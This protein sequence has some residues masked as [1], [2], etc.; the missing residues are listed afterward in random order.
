M[1][2][3]SNAPTPA[4]PNA[5]VAAAARLNLADKVRTRLTTYRP[6]EEWQEEAWAYYD[7]MPELKFG[8]RYLGNAM[9]KLRFFVGVRGDDPSEDPIPVTSEDAAQWVSPDLARLATET[10]DRLRGPLGDL[11]EITRELNSNLE[12]VGEC[13]L[14]G[15]MPRQVMVADPSR[16]GEMAPKLDGGQ[17]VETD[18]DWDIKSVSELKY[19]DIGSLRQHFPAYLFEGLPDETTK[20]WVVYDYPGAKKPSNVILPPTEDRP[21]DALIRIWTK[22]PRFSQVAD[23]P[24]RAL[25]TDCQILQT[26]TQQ[27][28]AEANSRMSAGVFL[29]PSELS[30]GP[31][32]QTDDGSEGGDADGDPLNEEIGNALGDPIA[33]PSSPYSVAPVLIRGPAE[34][35]KE[36]RHLTLDRTSETWL[37]DRIDK[38]IR[39]LANGVN[40][41]PEVL[42]GHDS[43]TF[44]NAKQI[45]QD[46]FDDYLEPRAVLCSNAYTEAFL[47]PELLAAD[48]MEQRVDEIDRLVVW[49]D[50]TRLVARPD[51]GEAADSGWEKGLIGDDE[52]RTAKGF[53]GEGAP[54]DEE[55]LRRMVVRR[56][57][58][59]ADVTWALLSL[60]EGLPEFDPLPEPP[61]QDGP[62][63][64]ASMAT[65]LQDV[66]GVDLQTAHALATAIAARV[67]EAHAPKALAAGAARPA[68]GR[69]LMDIDRELRTRL[70]VAADD[71]LTRAYERAGNR[72]QSKLRG[73]P[74]H[75]VRTVPAGYK[76]QMLGQALVAAAGIDEDDLFRDAF[77]ELERQFMAWGAQAQSEAIDVAS[78]IASG[79][80]VTEREALKLRQAEDLAEAWE[81]LKESLESFAHAGLYSPDPT[82]PDIGEFDPTSKV[83]SGMIRQAI[84]RAGGAQS[85]TVDPGDVW[86]AV[87]PDGRPVGGIGTGELI[88]DALANAGAGVEGYRWVYGPGFRRNEFEPHLRLDGTEFVTFD[89][90][91][92]VVS[93]SFPARS[94]YM[95]GDHRGCLC[96]FEP[97][98]ITPTEDG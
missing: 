33:D 26:L 38:R 78:Q 57:I 59:T 17:P 37:D 95:P 9:S 54:D 62:V 34:Y 2:R 43:T 93:G 7:A 3:P 14:V 96:D 1:A 72:L 10:L 51:M 6:P 86:V 65:R 19:E 49:Y 80:S 76:A 22:H 73:E 30:F 81:W 21:G 47:K 13:Y 15:I 46:E 90:P 27:M 61:P 28:L 48:G 85:F 97:V 71:A 32:D 58:L 39:R 64:E 74:A 25:L 41:P 50:E 35:L 67:D 55:R 79:F 92:L 70:L 69:R 4:G 94:H 53:D 5:L 89:D 18:E 60:F 84:A 36:I 77:A 11:A 83:P 66:I 88:R 91:K 87:L 12:V 56:G 98:I 20:L 29:V 24:M 44:S 40:L 75:M 23:S 8:A 45:D 31:V 16:P 63:D 68:P 42:L 82:A 52:W